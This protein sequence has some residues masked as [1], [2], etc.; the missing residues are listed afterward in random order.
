MTGS[1]VELSVPAG[2]NHD[3]WSNALRAPRIRQAAKNTDFTIEAKYDSEP[4]SRIQLQGLTVEQDNN[5]L[6]R[7][8]IYSDGS[9]TKIFAATFVNGVPTK[10][11]QTVIA[12]GKPT[13]LRI[14][15]SGN[16]FILTYSYD[17]ITFNQGTSFS[18]ALTVGA[19]GI[20]VGNAGATP[21]AYSSRVDYFKVDGINP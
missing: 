3:L 16:Q 13:Y 1:Q 9:Q 21:P 20:F 5:N 12:N 18:H 19:V 15:R 2:S 11:L 17:G 8:D 4:F 14:K 10:R 7:Y 6:V